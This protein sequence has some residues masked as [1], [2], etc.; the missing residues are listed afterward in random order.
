MKMSLLLPVLLGIILLISFIS[1]LILPDEKEQ[2]KSQRSL[3][4]N[5]NSFL[6]VSII[7]FFIIQSMKINLGYNLQSEQVLWEKYK[8]PQIDSTMVYYRAFDDEAQYRSRQKK[9]IYHSRK[10]VEYDLFDIF[11]IEDSFIN[12]KESLVLTTVFIMPNVYRDSSR[13]FMIQDLNYSKDETRKMITK[14]KYD[15]II[16][17][18]GLKNKIYKK[19]DIN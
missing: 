13:T 2:S 19:F 10:I 14:E 18:W 7:L 6:R 9:I 3:K 12:R 16:N 15:S 4:K 5:L 1:F 11:S 17:R 8:L